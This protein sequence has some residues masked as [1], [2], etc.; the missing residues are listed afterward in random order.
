MIAFVDCDINFLTTRFYYCGHIQG[1]FSTLKASKHHI[2]AHKIT[3]ICIWYSGQ[4]VELL[5]PI[6]ESL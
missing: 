2:V 1:N 4:Y 5:L 3:F 6:L